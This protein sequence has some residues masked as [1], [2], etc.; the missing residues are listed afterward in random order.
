MAKK[1]SLFERLTGMVRMDEHEDYFEHEEEQEE[2]P[3]PK[4]RTEGQRASSQDASQHPSESQVEEESEGQLAVDVYQT[5]NDIVVQTMV[6]GVRPE[7]ISITIARD[8]ITIRGRRE[9]NKA[10]SDENYFGR[11]LYWGTFS[12]TILLPQEIDPEGADATERHG[13]LMIRL[14]KLDKDR[15]TTIKI[16]S[17]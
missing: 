12:R 16:K 14:P 15:K 17:V 7:D 5:P 9:E 11:E 6:A 2:A 8:M 1:R 10:I 13:L 4:M 3:K